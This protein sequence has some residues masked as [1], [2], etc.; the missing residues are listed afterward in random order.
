VPSDQT[1]W[2]AGNAKDFED[3]I[4]DVGD[5]LVAGLKA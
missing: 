2:S 3:S 5:K 4:K 1:K